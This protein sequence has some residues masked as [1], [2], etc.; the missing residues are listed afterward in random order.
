MLK[1]SRTDPSVVEKQRC[2][3]IQRAAQKKLKHADYLAQLHRP[4]ENLTINRRIGSKLHQLYTWESK[5][6]GLCAYD[7]KRFLLED[8]V[9]SL[10]FGHRDITARVHNDLRPEGTMLIVTGTPQPIIE[11]DLYRP[12]SKPSMS[13]FNDYSNN[14]GFKISLQPSITA[15]NISQ[16]YSPNI[17]KT[18]LPFRTNIQVPKSKP[19]MFLSIAIQSPK[20]LHIFYKY[21]YYKKCIISSSG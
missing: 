9:Q 13:V 8:G 10:A 15:E 14:N 7:D 5:K 19:S 4:T 12:K 2:K 17:K 16:S 6:R 21:L 3:G 11:D 20:F 18:G 1:N